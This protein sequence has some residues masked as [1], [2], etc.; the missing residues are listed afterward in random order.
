MV[1]KYRPNTVKGH[2]LDEID[3]HTMAISFVDPIIY[4]RNKQVLPMRMQQVE[5]ALSW[6]ERTKARMQAMREN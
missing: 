6:N 2:H 4:R 1:A 5:E 3:K